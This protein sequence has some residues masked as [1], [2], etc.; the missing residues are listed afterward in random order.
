MRR[1]TTPQHKITT[2]IDLSSATVYVTY[3]QA[4]QVVFEKTND[5]IA[6]ATTVNEN[7]TYDHALVITLTQA[8]TLALNA[9]FDVE[10]QIRAAFADGSTIASPIMY[11]KVYDIL[12]DG[13]IEYL[14][15]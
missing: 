11:A 1:G 4:K 12:K 5:A 7:E 14:G 15:E 13:E 6:F 9:D 10:I 8:D 2:D 3:A